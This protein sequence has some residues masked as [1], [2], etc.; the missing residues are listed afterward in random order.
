MAAASFAQA[1]AGFRIYATA[2]PILPG[3]EEYIAAGYLTSAS[4]RNPN[5]FTAVRFADGVAAWRQTAMW[6]AETSGGL[7][8]AVP[9][10]QE[11]AFVQ[12]CAVRGQSVW[13]IGEVVEGEGI[14]VV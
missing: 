9:A 4:R 12:E 10:A 2:L 6:E 7:L 3:V 13:R 11:E 8:L 14:E 5:Y 1:G